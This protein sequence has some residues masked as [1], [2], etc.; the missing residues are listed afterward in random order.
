MKASVLAATLGR[1]HKRI[2]PWSE[3]F[4]LGE[5]MVRRVLGRLA[6]VAKDEGGAIVVVLRDQA[7]QPGGIASIILNRRR[8]Y[9]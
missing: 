4:D 3:L 1:G 9:L 8:A 2:A 7:Q 6:R 5:Q